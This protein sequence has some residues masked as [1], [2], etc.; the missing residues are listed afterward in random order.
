[1]FISKKNIILKQLLMS[2]M[3]ISIV[4][5]SCLFFPKGTQATTEIASGS[6]GDNV[7]W[8]L[9]DEGT[10]II[11]GTGNIYN[12]ADYYPWPPW[13]GNRNNIINIVINEGVTSIGYSA[14][15]NCHNLSSVTIPDSVTSIGESVFYACNSLNGI[16]IPDSVT[17]IGSSAFGGCESL[18]S[19]TI[20]NSVTSIGSYAFSGCKSLTTIT[21][22]NSVT[23]IENGTF[24]GCGSLTRITI[25]NSVTSI[26]GKAFSSC[27]SLTSITI[28]D[29]VT[30]IGRDAF[31]DCIS[32]TSVTIP[33]SV[34]YIDYGAF[35]GCTAL[36]DVYFSGTE[37][38]WNTITIDANNDC[39]TNA[40]IH[41]GEGGSSGGEESS[42]FIFPDDAFSFLNKEVGKL[43]KGYYITSSDYKRLKKNM[44]PSEIA[45]YL[46]TNFIF[47]TQYSFNVDGKM[48]HYDEFIG[49]CYGIALTS[50]LKYHGILN[51][52][53]LGVTNATEE[54]TVNDIKINKQLIS[55]INYY[56][57]QHNMIL[58][59][60]KENFRKLSVAERLDII[61][62]TVADG[63]PMVVSF[64]WDEYPLEFNNWITHNGHT[65]LAY[66][67]EKGS[68][69]KTVNKKT[70]NYK[71]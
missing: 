7:T 16:T 9:D 32:L 26:G 50:I 13:Y 35:S 58:K 17:S 30:S 64:N 29:S 11:S 23:K 67:A 65:V 54:R 52:D 53:D 45:K 38:E 6:C 60:L 22:P 34:T 40:T 70:I 56:H 43:S 10:L 66:G 3:L 55:T 12:D 18:T 27:D 19:I 41:F 44:S 21:I 59:N 4:L 24:Y 28:P 62:S 47:Y 68:W 51:F 46:E 37:S 8:T 1:M 33:K 71:N 15:D 39:L 49:S 25:P 63:T 36:A 5:S 61:A 2:I 48:K 31:S 57:I 42:G 20:P 69:K 14:F